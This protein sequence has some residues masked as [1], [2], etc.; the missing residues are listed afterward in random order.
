MNSILIVSSVAP[1]R[2]LEDED[3][4]EEPMISMEEVPDDFTEMEQAYANYVGMYDL[5]NIY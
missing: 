1:V 5:S 4:D 3:E 2:H